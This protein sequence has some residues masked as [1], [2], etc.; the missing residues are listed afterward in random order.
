MTCWIILIIS[1]LLIVWFL[2]ITLLIIWPVISVRLLV[3]FIKAYVPVTLM[4]KIF[5][6][7]IISAILEFSTRT[8]ALSNRLAPEIMFLN[9]LIVIMISSGLWSM[10]SRAVTNIFFNYYFI[11]IWWLYILIAIK[12]ILILIK[13]CLI[14]PSVIISCSLSGKISINL[15][16]PW[17]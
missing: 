6:I 5:I 4:L 11:N 14:D 12:T 10:I 16:I 9:I 2:F 8:I 3:T 7:M 1:F 13:I 17:F 15:A